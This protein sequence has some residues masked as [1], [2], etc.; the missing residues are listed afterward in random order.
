MAEGVGVAETGKKDLEVARVAG[1]DGRL[2]D[3][4][5]P[6]ESFCDLGPGCLNI[7]GPRTFEE[8]H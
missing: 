6:R 3:V 5:L 1:R 7:L 2:S 8:L 4:P